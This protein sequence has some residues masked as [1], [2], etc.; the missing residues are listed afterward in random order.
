MYI[1]TEEEGVAQKK[2]AEINDV[3]KLSTGKRHSLCLLH[4]YFTFLLPHPDPFQT[5][6]RVQDLQTF[7][8]DLDID[9]HEDGSDTAVVSKR[10]KS[11][12][13]SSR[14]SSSG[15]V[16]KRGGRG[17]ASATMTFLVYKDRKG[18]GGGRR[19]KMPRI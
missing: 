9:I 11:S 19:K 16:Y 4:T 14:K 6:H 10:A 13:S 12:S 8:R 18:A 15:R 17:K 5:L 2:T 3:A 7:L 1:Y